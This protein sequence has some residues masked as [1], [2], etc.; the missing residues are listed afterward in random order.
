[1]VE[2]P[3]SNLAQLI[4]AAK[5]TAD[6]KQCAGSPFS[7][8]DPAPGINGSVEDV[9]GIAK[10]IKDHQVVGYIYRMASGRFYAQALE[11]MPYDDQ[12]MANVIVADKSTLQKPHGFMYS[13]LSKIETFPWTD[14]T[15]LP[16][17]P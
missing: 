10:V 4:P 7:I 3:F 6:G 12:K 1:M 2:Q 17:N 8:H 15:L 9:I 14:L 16:C 13:S 5:S 11:S